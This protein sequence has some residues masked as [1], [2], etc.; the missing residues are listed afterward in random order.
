MV[1]G[2]FLP[3]FPGEDPEPGLVAAGAAGGAGLRALDGETGVTQQL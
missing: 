2:T 3:S 1:V